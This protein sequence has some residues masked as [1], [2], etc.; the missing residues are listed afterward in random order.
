MTNKLEHEPNR[1]FRNE[2][3][4]SESKTPVDIER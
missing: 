4:I 3:I 2:D 1:V